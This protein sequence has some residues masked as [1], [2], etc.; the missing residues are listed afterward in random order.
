MHGDD[1]HEGY[2]GATGKVISHRF[3]HCAFG[4]TT[5]QVPTR[6]EPILQCL[7]ETCVILIGDMRDPPPTFPRCIHIKQ[8]VRN[9][10]PFSLNCNRS[11]FYGHDIAPETVR[12]STDRVF[13]RPLFDFEVKPK[14][15]HPK[16]GFPIKGAPHGCRTPDVPIF[17]RCPP[18][19][20]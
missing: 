12:T 13:L 5:T 15:S 9:Q 19:K 17:G 1:L 11:Q 10:G 3:E 4:M 18:R 16:N 14:G 2:N 8:K 6:P 20:S 7:G